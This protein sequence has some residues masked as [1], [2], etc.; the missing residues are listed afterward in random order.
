MTTLPNRGHFLD[1]LGELLGRTETSER[2]AA[3]LVLNLD[4]FKLVNES[5][6]FDA[7]DTLLRAVAQRLLELVRPGD[8]VAR[9]QADSFAILL[10]GIQGVAEVASLVEGLM[11]GFARP[12]SVGGKELFVTVSMGVSLWPADGDAPAIL[13]QNAEVAVNRAKNAAVPAAS[14]TNAP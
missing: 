13:L 11:A 2:S 10:D 3:V 7:G 6:G 5:L 12:L 1:R 4:R 14:I 8:L 9:L